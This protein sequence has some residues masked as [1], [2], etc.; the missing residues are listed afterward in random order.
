MLFPRLSGRLDPGA[1][2]VA[3]CPQVQESHMSKEVLIEFA[4]SKITW[5]RAN[6]PVR[7]KPRL[8]Q[9]LR[10]RQAVFAAARIPYRSA[11][12]AAA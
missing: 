2:T 3:N 8:V 1:L 11:R 5:Y 9:R 4:I 10:Q 6:L 7:E 12:L